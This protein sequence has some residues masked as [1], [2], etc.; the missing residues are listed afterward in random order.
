MLK[1]PRVIVQLEGL[2]QLKKKSSTLIGNGT[3]DLPSCSIVS[4]PT[5]LLPAPLYKMLYGKINKHVENLEQ[6]Y[7][8]VLLGQF[9]L[10]QL[11]EDQV[12][13]T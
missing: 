11:K 3:R 9:W 6:E 10:M 13:Q 8:K 12:P 2:G 1:N 5:T 7:I 4:Q